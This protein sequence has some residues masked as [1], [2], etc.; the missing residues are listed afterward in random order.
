MLYSFF[1]FPFAR[2]KALTMSYDDGVPADKRLLEIFKS[3]GIKGAFHLNSARMADKTAEEIVELYSGQEISCHG[4][5]HYSLNNLPDNSV[6]QQLIEDR[7]A[8]EGICGSPVRGLSY[9]NGAFNTAIL[10]ILS[11]AGIVYSRTTISTQNFNMPENWLLW[12]PTCHHNDDIA[13]KAEKFKALNRPSLSLF[14]VW[15]HSY[16]FDN[17]NNWH[18]I[19]SFCEDISGRDDI[20]YATNIEIY[21]YM[22]A[23][24]RLQFSADGTMVFNPSAISVWLAANGKNHEISAG[25]LKSLA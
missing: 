1:L 4:K 6:L 8:L 9:P 14:Y 19:E 15:G 23:L 12:N 11:A 13:D 5:D 24:Y 2:R 7:I 20:W 17:Q 10:P 22:Q 21:D 3:N 25:E 16:E 18:I